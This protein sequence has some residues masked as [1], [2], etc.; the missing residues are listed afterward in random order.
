MPPTVIPSILA[1]NISTAKGTYIYSLASASPSNLAA[2]SSD[3][4]LRLFDPSSFQTSASSSALHVGSDEEAS[5]ITCLR[6]LPTANTL[7]T[8]GRD[9]I[10][11][12]FDIRFPL[13]PALSFTTI[14]PVLSLAVNPDGL[15]AA[16]MELNE[17]LRATSVLLFDPRFPRTPKVRYTESHND[18]VTTLAF[19]SRL[20]HLLLSGGTDALVN[21]YNVSVGTAG[22]GV[23]DQFDDD[24]EG[25]LHQVINH[26]SSVHRAGWMEEGEVWAVSHDEVL[27]VY[28]FYEQGGDEGPVEET[29]R[30]ELGD[31]RE[32][33]K[34]EYV[35]DVVTKNGG[36]YVV[37]G[38]HS[39]QWVDM[40]G[41][42]KR[43]MEVEDWGW[44]FEDGYRLAG[45]HGEEICRG[46]LVHEPVSFSFN[47]A[48][49]AAVLMVAWNRPAQYILAVKTVW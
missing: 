23:T 33:V 10:V 28:K 43:G 16:G 45:G 13:K 11:H 17:K 42:V 14:D 4:I 49:C 9:G 48:G 7:L 47:G 38:N 8:A 36:G 3:N 1:S 26:G 6:S 19:H 46:I 5:G 35:V 40:V 24:V 29:E 34:C 2:I 21:C 31:V 18:D 25:A 32:A 37:A 39:K 41:L 15:V 22:G 27:G 30:R 12:T 44:N 20:P